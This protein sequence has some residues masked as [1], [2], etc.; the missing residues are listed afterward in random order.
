MRGEG[1]KMTGTER[2]TR[3]GRKKRKGSGKC[4]EEEEE[5]TGS[6]RAEAGKRFQTKCGCGLCYYHREPY[7][8]RKHYIMAVTAPLIRDSQPVGLRSPRG[9]SYS[10]ENTRANES[11]CHRDRRRLS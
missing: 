5:K 3:E 7:Q 9:E 2:E 11:L 1:G 8:P 10:A 4:E 6:F